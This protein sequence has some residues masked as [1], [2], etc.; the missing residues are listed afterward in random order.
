MCHIRI[1]NVDDIEDNELEEILC[2]LCSKVG[3][4]SVL[5]SK[6]LMPN[7][8]KQPDYENRLQCAKCSWVCPIYEVEHESTIED[9]IQPSDNPFDN[10]QGQVLSVDSRATQR[11]KDRNKNMNSKG[12]TRRR[13][14]RFQNKERHKDPEVQEAI[15]R[16]LDVNI[17]HDSSSH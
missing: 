3:L 16:G 14:K 1:V 2:P 7:E 13:S 5:G 6:I 12:V 10:A 4:R 9:S 17:I 8:E 11:R 15:D